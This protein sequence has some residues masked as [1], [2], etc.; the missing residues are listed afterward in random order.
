MLQRKTKIHRR[1][2]SE[3]AKH[4]YMPG[5]NTHRSIMLPCAIASAPVERHHQHT[6]TNSTCGQSKRYIPTHNILCVIARPASR[7]QT[8][9][10]SRQRAS[11]SPPPDVGRSVGRH[12]IGPLERSAFRQ[13]ARELALG[14]VSAKVTLARRTAHKTESIHPSPGSFHAAIHQTHQTTR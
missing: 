11:E 13:R 3:K 1:L 10:A 8:Q 2:W 5:I 4:K 9:F 12:F 7:L 6:H 14:N